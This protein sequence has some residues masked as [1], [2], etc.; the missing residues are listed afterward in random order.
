MPVRT[1]MHA[2]IA[3]AALLLA[4]VFGA[5][6]ACVFLALLLGG[7]TLP[8]TPPAVCRKTGTDGPAIARDSRD[9]SST[10]SH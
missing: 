5:F 10:W 6:F 8:R 1:D 2:L 7:R 4:A 3:E 9:Y